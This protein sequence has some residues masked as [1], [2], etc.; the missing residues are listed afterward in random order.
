MLEGKE[1]LSGLVAE[2]MAAITVE[3]TPAEELDVAVAELLMSVREA[4]LLAT[5]RS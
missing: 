3:V 5:E 1:L 4:Q 2:I